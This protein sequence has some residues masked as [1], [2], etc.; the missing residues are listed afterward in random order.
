MP[1]ED[2]TETFFGRTTGVDFIGL[3]PPGAAYHVISTE[4]LEQAKIHCER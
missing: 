2:K 1:I 4:M 3:P